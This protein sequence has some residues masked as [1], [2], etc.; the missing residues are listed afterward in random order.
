MAALIYTNDSR[1]EGHLRCQ[2]DTVAVWIECLS[3]IPAPCPGDT[4]ANTA[5]WAVTL[6]H[7]PVVPAQGFWRRWLENPCFCK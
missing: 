3:A 7:D 4:R 2:M 5:K 6:N 1:V